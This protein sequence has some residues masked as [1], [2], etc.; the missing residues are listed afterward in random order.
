M[1]MEMGL[2]VS[3]LFPCPGVLPLGVWQ[4]QVRSGHSKR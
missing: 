3:A 4:A 1:G 2:G